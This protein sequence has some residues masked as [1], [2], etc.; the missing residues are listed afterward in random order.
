MAALDDE[1]EEGIKIIIA[2][3]VAELRGAA[4]VIVKVDGTHDGAV[5]HGL[6]QLRDGLVELILVDV[7]Q[8]RL[9]ELRGHTFHFAADGGVVVGQ[10]GV[11][12]LRVTDAHDK[13]MLCQVNGRLAHDRFGR[14]LEVDGDDA[15]DGAGGLVHQA[16]GLA[17]EH[18]L[19]VLADLGNFDLAEF[20]HVIVVVLTAQDGTDADL[21]R[22]RTGQAGTAQHIAGGV[23]VKATHL[24]ACI[25]NA[26]G[27]AADK[28]GRM[29][30]LAGLRG[31][32]VD[33]NIVDFV[34]AQGLDADDVFLVRRYN[35]HHVQIDGTCQHDTV[36]VV[37]V[38]AA[39]LGAAGG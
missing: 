14:I 8:D 3:G 23:A 17:E 26:L 10:V 19:G 36:V 29:L 33:V 12:A 24:A 15:A 2:H 25:H 37:G 4:A 34:K 21:E 5:A 11:A 18:I 31:Q 35:G 32:D 27:N 39:D 1:F 20:S 6:A 30:G 7:A 22:R 13:A 28:G 38:V 16:A 9:S